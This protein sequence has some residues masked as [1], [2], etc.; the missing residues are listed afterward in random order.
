MKVNH[1]TL[2]RFSVYTHEFTPM[3]GFSQ[4]AN[5]MRFAYR[6]AG[7][8]QAWAGLDRSVRISFMTALRAARE[9]QS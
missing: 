7:T 1:R 3:L 2:F 5:H 8:Q 9:I 4:P 6:A